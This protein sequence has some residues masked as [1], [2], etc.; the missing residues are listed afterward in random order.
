MSI[1]LEVCRITE[2]CVGRD[3]L[4]RVL[5]VGVV[6]GDDAGVEPDN[7]EFCLEALLSRPPFGRARPVL[8]RIRGDDL[9]VSYLEVDDGR[10]DDPGP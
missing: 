7:L 9:S 2:G 10:P 1:A 6:V 4:P 5:E 3:A 8:E